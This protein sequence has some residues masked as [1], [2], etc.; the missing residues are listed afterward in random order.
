M[1]GQSKTIFW[2]NIFNVFSVK[3]AEHL[4]RV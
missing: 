4:S 2:N 3:I 1:A